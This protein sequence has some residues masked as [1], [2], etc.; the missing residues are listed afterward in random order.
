MFCLVNRVKTD[1]IASHIR[2]AFMIA[3][4]L[5][6]AFT[7]ITFGIYITCL[8]FLSSFLFLS[9]LLFLY[10]LAF[11]YLFVSHLPLFLR[12]LIFVLSLF[13]SSSLS[14]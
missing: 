2:I 1:V 4:K 9:L 5:V 3:F 8:L 13:I 12:F 7:N 10:C 6:G 14:R 11:L